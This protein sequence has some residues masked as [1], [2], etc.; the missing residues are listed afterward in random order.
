MR[1]SDRSAS[2]WPSTHLLQSRHSFLPISLV[3]SPERCGW[4]WSTKMC[5][6]SHPFRHLL[7]HCKDCWSHPNLISL[8]LGFWFPFQLLVDMTETEYL[9]LSLT[10]YHRLGLSCHYLRWNVKQNCPSLCCWIWFGSSHTPNCCNTLDVRHNDNIMR[11][12]GVSSTGSASQY[13]NMLS[14]D[15][16]ITKWSN[17]AE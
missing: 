14:H 10:G 13:D 15:Y 7:L 3:T 16:W 8:Q 5:S 1:Q 2:S 9:L 12:C 11:A 6:G 17:H 4:F